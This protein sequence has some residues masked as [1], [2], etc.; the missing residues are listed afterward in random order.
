MIRRAL[1]TL[2]MLLALP[3][4]AQEPLP[5]SLES[6]RLIRGDGV[7]MTLEWRFAPGDD[8]ARANPDFDDAGWTPVR[9]LD[10]PRHPVGW[11]RRHFQLDPNL[12]DVPIVLRL[13]APGTAEV[14]LDG[15]RVLASASQV[16][17]GGA[18]TS[19]SFQ[20]TSPVIAVRYAC[21]ACGKGFLLRIESPQ[22]RTHRLATGILAAVLATVPL[23]LAFIHLGL[24]LSDRRTREN[25]FL[26]LTLASFSAIVASDAL[27]ELRAEYPALLLA[28]RLLTP[29]IIASVFF[30]LMTYYVLRRRPFPRTWIAFALVG[31]SAAVVT[32]FT[33]VNAIRNAIWSL[34]FILL[35]VEVFRLERRSPTRTEGGTRPLLVGMTV[36]QI[37]IVLQVLMV[38]GIIPGG[39]PWGNVYYVGLIALAIGSSLFT[40]NTFA[41][42]R[43]RLERNE[44]EIESARK[45]QEAMLPK[46]LPAVEGIGVAAWLSTASEV[47]GDYYD[48]REPPEG[49]LLVVIGDAAG[50]GLAAGAMVTAIKAL[51]AGVRGDEDLA[52]FLARTDAVLRRMDL[53][54]LHM[55]LSLVRITGT[56]IEVCS[57]A[58]PPA[59]I[60]RASTGLVEELGAGGLP[61][62]GRLQGTWES[63]RAELRPGDTVLL[64]SDGLAELLDPTGEPFGFDEVAAIFGR[65]GDGSAEE[66]LRRITDEATRWQGKAPQNDDITLVVLTINSPSS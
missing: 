2:G 62:G 26:A 11:Y 54:L 29:A 46:Q 39:F 13:Q 45:L 14:F 47:G 64:A 59:L 27:A 31:A 34:Y 10:A 25:L 36:L 52:D 37:A 28:G 38:A 4:A 49:G 41:L 53:R 40:V 58:M 9:P 56:A 48:F 42:T 57:A 44:G 43:R 3:L 50:H 32:F 22:S 23:V 33:P 65:A 24:Y 30:S 66:V 21:D 5:A 6:G 15:R 1:L 12:V 35:I 19:V 18:W 16:G 51:F 17:G 20:S 7:D 60:R 55:C 8:L 63:R 61:L